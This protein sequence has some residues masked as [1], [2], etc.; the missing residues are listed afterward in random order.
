MERPNRDVQHEWH[1]A[2]NQYHYGENFKRINKYTPWMYDAKTIADEIPRLNFHREGCE[3]HKEVQ[4]EKTRK[5]HIHGIEEVWVRFQVWW[6][7]FLF[8]AIVWLR[9]K[10]Q[11][12]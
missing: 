3:E 2:I 4:M 1:V 9:W 8:D 5:Y 6:Q 10:T 12:W 11:W 7:R